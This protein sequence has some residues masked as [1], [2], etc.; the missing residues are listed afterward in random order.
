MN[1]YI[2]LANIYRMHLN[3]D[4]GSFFDRIP[5]GTFILSY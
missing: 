4:P 5:A 1:L 3:A 2:F